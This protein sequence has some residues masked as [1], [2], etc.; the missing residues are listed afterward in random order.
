MEHWPNAAAKQGRPHLQQN[1]SIGRSPNEGNHFE[2]NP[3]RGCG[4]H[5]HHRQFSGYRP[6]R[7]ENDNL[8]PGGTLNGSGQPD[9]KT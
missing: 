1:G 9:A 2:P 6:A 8:L 3:F 7:G 5:S 4:R